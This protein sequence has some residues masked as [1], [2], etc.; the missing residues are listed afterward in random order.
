MVIGKFLHFNWMNNWT[1]KEILMWNSPLFRLVGGT[2]VAALSAIFSLLLLWN[3][4]Y[5]W[6]T[7]NTNRLRSHWPSVESLVP[8]FVVR[9]IHNIH[10][11]HVE[12]KRFGWA[13]NVF[14]AAMA[15][16]GEWELQLPGLW[17]QQDCL[18]LYN[19]VSKGL[20]D[21]LWL[22]GLTFTQTHLLYFLISERSVLARGTMRY[23]I[24]TDCKHRQ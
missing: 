13:V 1:R 19:W 16:G 7:T 5:L 2:V 15:S 17:S 10:V 11:S 12:N 6:I 9:C 22:M 23:D 8:A 24:S 20:L 14:E 3:L 18:R 21:E 4:E